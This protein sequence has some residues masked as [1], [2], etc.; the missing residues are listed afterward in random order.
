MKTVLVLLLLASSV[1]AANIMPVGT[2]LK[3]PLK[4]SVQ[5]VWSAIVGSTNDVGLPVEGHQFRHKSVQCDG[6]FSSTVIT[7]EGSNDGTN[8]YPLKDPSNTAITCSAAGMF[9]IN[10]PSRYIRPRVTTA[11]TGVALIVNLVMTVN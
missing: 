5:T 6:T 1:F 10:T 3:S 7:I 4:K 11:G 2:T 9:Q 8:Y